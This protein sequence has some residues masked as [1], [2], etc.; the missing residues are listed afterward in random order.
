MRPRGLRDALLADIDALFRF[1]L[2]RVGFD[3]AIAE[4]VLQQ[5]AEIAL[6]A[7]D[8]M[9]RDIVSVEGWLRGVARNRVSH[10]WREVAKHNG[11]SHLDPETSRRVLA[12][13][14]SSCPP[15]LLEDTET[16]AAL[17]TAIASL[18]ADDQRLLYAFYR[19]GRSCTDLAT[20]LGCSTKGV[21]MRL[22]RMR[23][24][25]RDALNTCGE[26]Q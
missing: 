24:R 25:L 26:D 12:M 9:V 16:R 21:E 14:E 17:L 2:V 22:Y 20:D 3:E 4:D 11:T 7:D 10:Y 19:H 1:I 8:D 6:R 5:T 23:A 13:L 15:D 18:S